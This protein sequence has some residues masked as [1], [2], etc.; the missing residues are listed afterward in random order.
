[1]LRIH[2]RPLY[3]ALA[4]DAEHTEAWVGLKS[5]ASRS[6]GTTAHVRPHASWFYSLLDADDAEQLPAFCDRHGPLTIARL[7]LAA[8]AQRAWSDPR[9]LEMTHSPDSGL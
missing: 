3:V 2:N 8:A 4:F 5:L 7:P 1:M 9:P 6:G